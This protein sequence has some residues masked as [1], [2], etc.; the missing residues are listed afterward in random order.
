MKVFLSHSTKDGAFVE[1]LS[2]ALKAAGCDPWYGE[3]DIGPMD[4]FVRSISDALRSSDLALLIWSTNAAHSVWTTA[5]WT[6][7]LARQVEE[8]MIRL[9]IVMLQDVPLPEL[10]RTTNYVDARSDQE[11][12]ITRTVEWSRPDTMRPLWR[13]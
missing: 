13:T 7:V 3:V 8:S 5:E 12:A 9:G 11:Q 10:L 1:K 4:N 2:A 6:A